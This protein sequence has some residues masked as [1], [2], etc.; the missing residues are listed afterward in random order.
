MQS[1]RKLILT[2]LSICGMHAQ[3]FKSIPQ[4]VLELLTGNVFLFLATVAPPTIGSHPN[5]IQTYLSICAMHTQSYE[6]ISHIVL[7]LST[8]NRFSIFSTSSSAHNAIT[9]ETNPNL[10]IYMWNAHTKFRVD[11]S[12]STRVIDRKP[13]FYF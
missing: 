10:P 5:P 3:S 2:Y 9:P 13:F 8:R 1:C 12:N 6:S 4:I 11:T 7:K